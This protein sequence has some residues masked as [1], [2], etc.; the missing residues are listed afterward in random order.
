MTYTSDPITI[1]NVVIEENMLFY[2]KIFI[3]DWVH[4]APIMSHKAS[5]G[6]MRLQAIVRYGVD[7]CTPLFGRN[8]AAIPAVQLCGD[9]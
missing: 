2:V 3:E 1:C 6:G 5:A 9:V 4:Y 7:I 8:S